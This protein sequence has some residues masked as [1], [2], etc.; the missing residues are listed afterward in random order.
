VDKD[1]ND[2]HLKPSDMDRRKLREMKRSEETQTLRAGC[3]KAEPKNFAPPQTP[4]PVAW[5]SQNLI[6]WRWSLP[7]PTDQVWWR[8]M[9]A[10]S[11][12]R[13]NRPTHRTHKHTNRQDRLQ[14]TAPQLS[15]QGTN[16]DGCCLSVCLSV[17][18]SGT[19]PK[20]RTEA[21]SKLKIGRKECHDTS[22]PWPCLEG[23]RPKVKV[24]R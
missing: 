3:S 12:Y 2:L 5:D 7:S 6:S 15:A 22:D 20:W 24:I 19:R 8:S 14:Y 9:H 4:F 18:P 11:S 17:C 16:V 23:E 10:I 1:V 21:L 13:G